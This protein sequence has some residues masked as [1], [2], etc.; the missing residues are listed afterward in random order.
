MCVYN[1]MQIRKIKILKIQRTY[2]KIPD[3]R[4]RRYHREGHTDIYLPERNAYR[5]QILRR[6]VCI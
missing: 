4:H 3:S 6:A 5:F 2:I 1:F